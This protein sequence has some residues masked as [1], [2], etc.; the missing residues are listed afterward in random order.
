MKNNNLAIFFRNGSRPVPRAVRMMRVAENLGYKSIFCGALRENDILEKDTWDGFDIVRVGLK[1]PLLNGKKIFTYIKY[2]LI[3]S[4]GLYSY[5]K[6]VKPKLLVASDFEVMIP[7]ILYSKLYKVRLIYNIHD[8]LAQRYNLPNLVC[9]ILNYFEG[10]AT[11][12]SES[13]LVPEEFRKKSLPFFCQHKIYVVKNT[14][15]D[16]KYI[17]PPLYN[18]KIR[19]FYGG[20][21]NWGRGIRELLQLAEK[22]KNI[23]L[24]IAGSGS[25]EIVEFIKKCDNVKYLGHISHEQSLKETGKAHFIPSFYNPSTKINQYAASNKLAESLAIGR[26]LLLNSEMKIINSFNSINCYLNYDYKNI[27]NIGNDLHN[28]LSNYD[29]YLKMC[30]ESRKIFKKQYSWDIAKL[31]MEKLIRN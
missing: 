13:A 7:A 18:G 30:K 19:L 6:K 14:P 25:D 15:G 3:F 29:K 24:V 23:E 11:V 26:P 16:I 22:N 31:N 5:F 20:W 1:Y 17:A 12:L 4:F 2:T 27:I 28:L 9:L 8:N 21:L 10:L